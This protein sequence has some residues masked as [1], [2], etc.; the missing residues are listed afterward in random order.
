LYEGENVMPDQTSLPPNQKRDDLLPVDIV[1]PVYNERPEAC[2]GTLAACMRQTYP[3]SK[4]FVVDDGSQQPVT[5]PDWARS[6]PC[7]SLVRLAKNQGISAARNAAI[8][9]SKTSLL[10]CIN[11][12]VL[13]N[14]DW[15]ASCEKYLSEHPAVG[16]CYTRIDPERPNRILTRWRVRFHEVKFGERSGPSSFAPG[17]AVLFRRE[18]VDAVHGYDIRYRRNYEDSDICKRMWQL[19]WETHYVANSRC[20]SRQEDS[21]KNL[22][23]KQLLR[24]S[25]WSSLS[26]GS[27]IRLCFS[28]CKWTLV[29]T[30]RNISKGRLFFIAVDAAIWAR[31]VWIAAAHA[32]RTSGGNNTDVKGQA[33]GIL[34]KKSH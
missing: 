15:L 2:A 32:L 17:H 26:E 10:A 24:D 1:I 16:A 4:I 30:C 13:P 23:A 11:A 22:A 6:S 33:N 3:V 31:A 14:P 21:L 29:R 34:A 12:E 7:I 5:L 27:P 28:L 8:A 20:I 18:A 19:G 25:G 9:C